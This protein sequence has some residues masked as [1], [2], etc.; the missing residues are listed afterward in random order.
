MYVT[1]L[2]APQTVNTMP[3]STLEAVADHGVVT[4]DTVRGGYDEAAATLDALE[5]LG[6]G[7]ADVTDQLE[8]E[9]VEKFQKSW[10][11]LLTT[12]SDELARLSVT[13]SD[14]EAYQ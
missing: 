7:Y 9:G 8:R 13:D 6:I 12:V 4:G 11:E 14:E 5:R 1:R 10:E 2:V 3:G